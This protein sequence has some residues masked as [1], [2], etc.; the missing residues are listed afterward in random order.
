MSYANGHLLDIA[1]DHVE[2]VEPGAYIPRKDQNGDMERWLNGMTVHANGSEAHV[3]GLA[4]DRDTYLGWVDGGGDTFDCTV[5]SGYLRDLEEAGYDGRR[6]EERDG[7][8]AYVTET[9]QYGGIGGDVLAFVEDRVVD[10]DERLDDAVRSYLDQHEYTAI[11]V[12]GTP[13]HAVE[14]MA[15][16]A[17]TPYTE[18]RRLHDPHHEIEI[19]A[20]EDVAALLGD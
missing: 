2:Q 8:E 13:E 17:A 5:A 10:G 20:D 7:L 16:L 15:M 18:R 3:E 14:Q 12:E 9:A 19:G 11:A 4:R 1:A 6:F